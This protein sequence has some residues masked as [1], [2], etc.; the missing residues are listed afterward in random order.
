MY[1]KRGKRCSLT[2][3]EVRFRAEALNQTET[4]VTGH[5][6]QN[7]CRQPLPTLCKLL[8]ATRFSRD[9]RN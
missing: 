2:R 6:V 8:M 7:M 5:D 9:L 1:L 4:A 3:H